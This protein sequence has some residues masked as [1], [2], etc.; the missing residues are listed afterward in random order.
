MDLLHSQKDPTEKKPRLIDN[1]MVGGNDF[2]TGPKSKLNPPKRTPTPGERKKM[3]AIW[4]SL[5][6][7]M[8][9]TN[10]LYTFGGEDRKQGSGGPIGDVLTQAM[11]RHM[12]NEF[13]EL[14]TGEMKKLDI[15]NEL[16]DR[17]A[18]DID[19]ANRSIGR[20]IKFC[21]LDGCMVS[22]TSEEIE[23]DN[24]KEED[25]LTMIELK[26]IADNI[27]DNIVTEHDFPS[28][29]PELGFKV[30]VLDLAMWVEEVQIP[31]SGM[32]SQGLHSRCE[33]GDRACLPIDEMPPQ[34]EVDP[35]PASRMVQ[36]VQFEFYSKPMAPSRV[37]LESSAQPWGQK[38]TTLT[39]ELIR[40]LLNCRKELGCDVK[41][42]HLNRFMQLLKNSG[43]SESF[44]V[45][46]M[47]SGLAGYNKI[48]TADRLGQRPIYRLRQWRA[49]ARRMEKLKKKKNWLGPFWKSAIFVPP[50]PGS[51]LKKR[52]QAKEEET[53]AG[54]R[55]A[56]PIKIIETAGK[57]L[58]QTLVNNDPFNGNKCTDAKCVPNNNPENKIN[59]RR[60]CV[61]YQI[62]CKLC[63]EAGKTETLATCYYGESGKNIHCRAKEHISKFNSTK[64][65]TRSESAFIKHLDSS[66]GGKTGIKS[67]SDY[68]SIKVLK[69]YQKAFTKCV[70]EGTYMANHKGELLNSKSEWHQAKVIR[71]TTLVVQGGAE[72]A[73]QQQ[74]Q[75]RAVQQQ[76]RQAQQQERGVQQQQGVVEQ[77]QGGVQRGVQQQLR[78]V[79]Q[80]QG[81]VQG[82]VQ[83]QQRGVQQQQGGGMDQGGVQQQQQPRELRRRSPRG[84]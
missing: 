65:K 21:P 14:F 62:T 13:D 20:R 3:I 78:S 51:E 50:T 29:H 57:T 18:D 73:S 49:S 23:A 34:M 66:H 2:R 8:I 47:K 84:Q 70:E 36:Q 19:L 30:P 5:I 48:L 46:I 31:A 83:Q 44:R 64:E 24:G 22:K 60:N 10:F 67:F 79:Q 11:A 52:L 55:E 26:K 54:G 6:V 12:G 37:I 17:Y 4:M 59:R 38:R 42:K 41:Q 58:E 40:R 82:G 25:E 53:R 43:Y 81:G 16:Y 74:Q 80:Q 68:F 9:M 61:C 32:D 33:K 75:Q 45:E 76:Q 69:A 56:Y 15:K 1:E 63:L 39:Q 27:M 35:N 77:Q 71:T 28:N 7:K 72:V